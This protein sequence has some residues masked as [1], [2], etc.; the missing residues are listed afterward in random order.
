M[1]FI[2][3]RDE[4]ELYVKM[5]G[6][7]PPVVLVHGWPLNADSWDAQALGL[8]EA[9]YTVIAYDRRGF[10]RSEQ[11]WHG[12]D[13]DTFADDLADVLDA[14]DVEDAA[15]IGFS[16]GGGEIAR[17]MSRHEGARVV[18]AGLIGAVTPFLLQTDDHPNGAPQSVF[19]GMMA[20]VRADRAE[21]MQ[22]F[23]KGFFGL[24]N[25]PEALSDSAVHHH[26]NMAM[27]AGLHPTLQCIAAFGTTDFRADM[28]A[29]TVPTLIVHGTADSIVPIDITARVAATMITDATLIEYDGAPHG[30]AAT[31]ADRLTE[32]LI[33]FLDG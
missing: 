6:D 15:I 22:G 28:A 18:K 13:Y 1:P 33:E 30:L 23:L 9:G 21:F 27:M 4:T 5:W 7:G 3:T 20:G 8:A 26:W 10:G 29:F 14:V 12:Y 17:Y 2:E 11:P 25:N 31:H 32:D 19:D 16:M 24:E